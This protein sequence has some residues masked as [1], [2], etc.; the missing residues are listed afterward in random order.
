VCF[1]PASDDGSCIRINVKID[2]S[3]GK[4]TFSMVNT[5]ELY[6]FIFFKKMEQSSGLT[7]YIFS[8]M[9]KKLKKKTKV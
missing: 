4:S 6:F 8:I 9:D 1:G 3:K 2:G 5:K 7:R